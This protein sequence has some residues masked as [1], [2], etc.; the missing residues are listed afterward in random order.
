VD[1]NS[2]V[3]RVFGA[4]E[5]PKIAARYLLVI[6]FFAFVQYDFMQIILYLAN[7]TK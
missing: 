4:R 6:I 5:K 1:P 7:S 3:A 2:D